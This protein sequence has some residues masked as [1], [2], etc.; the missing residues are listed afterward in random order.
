MKAKQ[1]PKKTATKTAK[2]S[3]RNGN[4][5]PVG[6]HPGNTG[7]KPGR[8]GRRPF[9]ITLAAQELVDKH[10]LLNVAVKIAVGPSKDTDRLAAIRLLVEYG[11]GRAPQHITHANDDEHPLPSPLD[12]LRREITRLAPASTAG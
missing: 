1:A 11:Y 9:A 6:A 2:P 5:L 4:V 8:S 10:D 7:G 12:D 3:G